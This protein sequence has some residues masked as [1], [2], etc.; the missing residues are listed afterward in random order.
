MPTLIRLSRRSPYYK[1]DDLIHDQELRA[2][3][4]RLQ[5][6]LA[7]Q[8]V[9]ALTPQIVFEFVLLEYPL[10]VLERSIYTYY[11]VW[12]PI[13]QIWVKICE[14]EAAI[15]YPTIPGVSPIQLGFKRSAEY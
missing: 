15:V 5:P 8:N 3:S 14:E 7:T 1:I 6:W 12:D 10:A 9:L 2:E 11:Y 13:R 4:E